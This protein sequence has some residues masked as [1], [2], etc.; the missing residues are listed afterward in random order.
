MGDLRYL[1]LVW[2]FVSLLLR[3]RRL[4]AGPPLRSPSRLHT[5]Q[6]NFQEPPA[7]L[8]R[9]SVNLEQ[10][11][12]DWC[13]CFI[14]TICGRAVEAS[15]L[16]SDGSESWRWF[17]CQND[18]RLQMA[19]LSSPE[20]SDCV[21]TGSSFSSGGRGR[22]G[23][24]ARREERTRIHITISR[25]SFMLYCEHFLVTVWYWAQFFSSVT[26]MCF[27]KLVIIKKK[28]WIVIYSCIYLF[29]KWFDSSPK[30]LMPILSLLIVLVQSQ[31]MSVSQC[32]YIY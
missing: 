32:I 9:C 17:E 27:P 25:Q 23:V 8:L 2:V 11:F 22:G 24:A 12:H 18:P 1:L 21:Y 6:Q 7:V 13:Q 31:K 28:I 16:H 29:L 19:S 30:G 3:D 4:G 14:T 10:S 20:C 15:T 26:A 5:S